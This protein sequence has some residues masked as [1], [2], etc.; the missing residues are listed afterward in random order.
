MSKSELHHA[1]EVRFDLRPGW[2]DGKSSATV[3]SALGH[4]GYGAKYA[5]LVLAKV[6][7]TGA[8]VHEVIYGGRV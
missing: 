8:S 1:V 5:G 7:E 4:P 6:V 3:L 2:V